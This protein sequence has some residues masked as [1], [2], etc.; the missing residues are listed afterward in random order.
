MPKLFFSSRLN[1]ARKPRKRS[2]ALF[3]LCASLLA[4]GACKNIPGIK[5]NVSVPPVL[6]PLVEADAPQMFDGINRIARVQSLRGKFDVQFLDNSFARCGVAEKYATADGTIVLQ[7]PGQ[8]YLTIQVPFIGSKVAEMTS[9]GE[10]FRVAILQGEEKFRR[11]VRG[12]NSAVYSK[13]GGEATPDCGGDG[14]GK[15]VEQRTVGALSGLRPQHVVDALLVQPVAQAGSNLIYSRSEEFVEE[16]APPPT[17]AGNK[18]AKA[19]ANVKSSG[20]VVRGYYVLDELAPEGAGRA[21]L[22]RR[23]WFDRYQSLRLARMQTYDAKGAIVTDVTYR[24][25][26]QVGSAS[27][28]AQY[29]LPTVIEITRPQDRYAIRLSFQSPE[30]VQLDKQ[31]PVSVF[32][33]ENTTG[34]QELD[35]DKK[36]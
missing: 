4:S 8:I 12:T 3:L 31:Y 9:D 17:N 1:C 35:L 18:N 34:L 13:V 10:H 27:E 15:M 36:Q 6:S 7:R 32:Q 30:A 28:G 26:K 2:V 11:F 20:R 19:S 33:L 24:D 29:Q 22:L 5:R 25:P 21:R 16:N 23:F 14:K